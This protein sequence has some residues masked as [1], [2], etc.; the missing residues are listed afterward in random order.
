MV[1]TL[2]AE[3]IGHESLEWIGLGRLK[4]SCPGAVNLVSKEGGQVCIIQTKRLSIVKGPLFIVS[5]E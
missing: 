1:S 3:P 4:G 2:E 5:A